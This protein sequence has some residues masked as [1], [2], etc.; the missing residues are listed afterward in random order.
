MKINLGQTNLMFPS[1]TILVGV[2]V[3]GKSNYIT[4]THA[5]ALDLQTIFVSIRKE[6]TSNLGFEQNRSFSI[7]VPS[8]DLV[9]EVDFCGSKS[10]KDTDK[11]PLF[12]TF[13]GA[14]GTAPMIKECP[15]NL[16]CIVTMKIELPNY[17]GYVGHI[18]NSMID[19]D[20]ITNGEVDYSKIQPFYFSIPDMG[21]WNLGKRFADSWFPYKSIK[22]KAQLDQG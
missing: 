4:V 17:N 11:A 19:S 21:Y 16:E 9:R 1:I 20:F 15:I 5:G 7:N 14:L 12:N 22:P 8:V 6:H 2:N 13:Y 3:D 18:N 10:G